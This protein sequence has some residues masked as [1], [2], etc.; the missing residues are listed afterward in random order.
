M[1]C[2]PRWNSVHLYQPFY[3]H[4]QKLTRRAGESGL[5][6]VVAG[7][8]RRTAGVK[9]TLLEANARPPGA[10][11]ALLQILDKCLS[12]R[13]RRV[14]LAAAHQPALRERRRGKRDSPMS[15]QRG[16]QPQSQISRLY[17]RRKVPRLASS[18]SA[19]T[20]K[21]SNNTTT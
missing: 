17:L 9:A 16:I 15:L 12:L 6:A 13:C 10:R 1:H 3:Q 18:T 21:S 2:W 11:L 19:A 4:N 8:V 20:K 7:E 14:E 5:E